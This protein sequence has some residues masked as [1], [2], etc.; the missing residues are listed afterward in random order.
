MS[1]APVLPCWYCLGQDEDG[2]FDPKVTTGWLCEACDERLE[3]RTELAAER[4][5]V[6]R[7]RSILDE[8]LATHDQGHSPCNCLEA[9]RALEETKS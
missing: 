3:F 7:F 5:K 6:E 4:A 9:R 8:T 2:F 1:D